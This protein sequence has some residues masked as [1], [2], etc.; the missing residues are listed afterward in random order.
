MALQ[1]Q[2]QRQQTGI[3]SSFLLFCQVATRYWSSHF[4]VGG[5]FPN[6]Y[7]DRMRLCPQ[8]ENQSMSLTSQLKTP[9]KDSQDSQEE[10]NFPSSASLPLTTKSS[11]L[12]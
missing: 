1:N 7:S 12:F 4:R 6:L 2:P 9:F 3:T 11:T 10:D 5:F 8:A